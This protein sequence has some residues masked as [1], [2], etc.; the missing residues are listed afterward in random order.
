MFRVRFPE[1]NLTSWPPQLGP[2][3]HGIGDVG[4]PADAPLTTQGFALQGVD[5]GLPV[6]HT[7][8]LTIADS[9]PRFRLFT[10]PLLWIP[11]LPIPRFACDNSR[12]SMPTCAIFLWAQLWAGTWKLMIFH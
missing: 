10:P 3:L 2:Q 12:Q 7:G 6:A 8:D 4:Q 1:T 11:D 9:D 5:G